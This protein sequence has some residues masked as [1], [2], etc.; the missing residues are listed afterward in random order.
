MNEQNLPPDELSSAFLDGELA[1]T[2]AD[3]VRNDPALAARAD[4][5]RRAGDAV[6]APVTP[7]PGAEDAAV[8]AALAD[9]DARGITTLEP[10]SRRSRRLSLITGVAA[11]AA[12][13]FIVAAAAGLFT[14]RQ[15]AEDA[16]ATAAAPPPAAEAAAAAEIH[17]APADEAAPAPP[18]AAEAA[19]PQP[20]EPATELNRLEAPPTEALQDAEAAP[21]TVL[22]PPEGNEEAV[23]AAGAALSEAQADAEAARAEAAPALPPPEAEPAPPPPDS[24]T[25][26]DDMDNMAAD[27]MG[28]GTEDEVMAAD[29]APESCAAAVGDG[30]VD[31]RIT[32][33]DTPVLIVRTPDGQITALD[34]TTC[35]EIPPTE[36]RD[37]TTDPPPE[38]CAV[39]DG[40]V[41]LRITAGDTP[42]LIVRTPDGQI[43]A[44]DAT[45][46]TEIPPAE[47]A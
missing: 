33:G 45:T 46:C 17:A 11:A 27:D 31:L 13:G 24:D 1:E 42:V 36:A 10:A 26:A 4:E 38:S 18:P 43:T 30:T 7:P 40:T 20:A 39:G 5:L 16:D 44:L 47:P 21:Q 23:A 9:F 22:I 6:G 35:T 34:A 19:P 2:A 12:V 15:A 25:A 28:D 3:A 41:D 8:D 37:T 32:A 29:P 14:E